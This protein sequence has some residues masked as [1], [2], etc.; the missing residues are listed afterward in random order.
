M[1]DKIAQAYIKKMTEFG[2]SFMEENAI[3]KVPQVK[4]FESKI[5]IEDLEK[6]INNFLLKNKKL[7]MR[8]YEFEAKQIE[9]LDIQ[10]NNGYW[11][12]WIKYLGNVKEEQ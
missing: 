10:Y 2:R 9:K 8:E 6:Q 3:A 1:S 11:F 7:Q 5:G 12:C 4:L